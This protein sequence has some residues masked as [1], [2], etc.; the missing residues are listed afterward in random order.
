MALNQTAFGAQ[1]RHDAYVFVTRGALLLIVSAWLS[2]AIT[3]QSLKRSIKYLS[4]RRWSNAAYATLLIFFIL[5]PIYVTN[6]VQGA[7][8]FVVNYFSGGETLSFGYVAYAFVLFFNMFVFALQTGSG[9]ILET[10]FGGGMEVTA[11]TTM[12]V[13]GLLFWF[14]AALAFGSIA[15][16]LSGFALRYLRL[17]I[18][19]F[20][21]L[22]KGAITIFAGA[23]AGFAKFVDWLLYAGHL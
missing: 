19:R 3:E 20:L 7:A 10:R 23:I 13:F 22:K 6:A 14:R 15:W 18:F 17:V 8:V 12:I 11:G 2:I 1:Y 21:E 16:W 9:S 4:N 5:A